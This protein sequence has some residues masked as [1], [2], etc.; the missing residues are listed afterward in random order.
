M[1]TLNLKQFLIEKK[2]FEKAARGFWKYV[3]S[4]KEDDPEE[5]YDAFQ[6][7]DISSI[8][9]ENEKIALVIHYRS[10][11][12][13]EFVQ[14]TV[15][16]LLNAQLIAQYHYLQELDGEVMDDVLQFL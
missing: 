9:I 7:N 16:V 3:L 10:E 12:P 1:D 5:F 14:S 13:I 4:W 11:E 15:N 6:T 2:S 8:T